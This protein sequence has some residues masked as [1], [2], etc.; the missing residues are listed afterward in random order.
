MDNRDPW[1]KEAGRA[2]YHFS[3]MC[4]HTMYADKT[5]AGTMTNFK[6]C[7]QKSGLERELAPPATHVMLRPTTCQLTDA[8]ACS[9]QM[10]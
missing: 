4:K 10:Q 1:D 8:S 3:V 5:A 2:V 7:A 9:M 6:F